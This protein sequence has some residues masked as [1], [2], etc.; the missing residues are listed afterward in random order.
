MLCFSYLYP[1]WLTWICLWCL[2]WRWP[3]RLLHLRYVP[4]GLSS[5]FSR[6]TFATMRTRL[7]HLYNR[8]T[9]GAPVLPFGWRNTY[10]I[11][12]QEKYKMQTVV[13]LDHFGNRFLWFKWKTTKKYPSKLGADIIGPHLKCSRPRAEMCCEPITR[14][15]SMHASEIWY[16]HCTM[17]IDNINRASPNM[18]E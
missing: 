7:F 16:G 5:L 1:P 12:C 4:R 6:R 10:L 9:S 11:P 13:P 18:S 17:W 3:Y 2:R 14:H 15:G 8:I